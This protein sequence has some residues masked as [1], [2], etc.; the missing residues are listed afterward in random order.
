GGAPA[1]RQAIM[2]I[3]QLAIRDWR[4]VA[5]TFR[6]RLSAEHLTDRGSAQAIA[7][8]ERVGQHI[9]E[10]DPRKKLHDFCRIDI[11]S[12][13][14]ERRLPLLVPVFPEAQQIGI[15]LIIERELNRPDVIGT[16]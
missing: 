15:A 2:I 14:S 4:K 1:D 3:N 11:L 6:S 5:R 7:K 16:Q 8:V 13:R 12:S 10:H 9:Y